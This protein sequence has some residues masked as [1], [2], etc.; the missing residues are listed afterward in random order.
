[1]LDS[2]VLQLVRGRE[3]GIRTEGLDDAEPPHGGPGE[4]TLE[5]GVRSFVSSMV[6]KV[7]L[8]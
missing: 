6:L 8:L 3:G 1:V 5:C 4:S 7:L 2:V